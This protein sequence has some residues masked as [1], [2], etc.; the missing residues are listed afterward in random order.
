MPKVSL[1]VSALFFY[2]LFVKFGMVGSSEFTETKC[3]LVFSNVC[4][5]NNSHR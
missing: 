1:S 2:L 3:L 5:C 4:M